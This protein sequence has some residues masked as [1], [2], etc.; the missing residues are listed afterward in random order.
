[1]SPITYEKLSVQDSFFVWLENQST[2]M[3]VSAISIFDVG[4]LCRRSRRSG[5]YMASL[6]VPRRSRLRPDS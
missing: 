4:P 5:G 1:M 2:P 6:A 3:H